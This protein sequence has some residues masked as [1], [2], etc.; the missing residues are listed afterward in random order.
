MTLPSDSKTP[1]DNPTRVDSH[2]HV[3]TALKHDDLA[4]ETVAQG[5]ALSGHEHLI[6]WETVRTFKVASVVCLLAAFSA[7]ADGYEIAVQ[8]SIIANKGFIQQFATAVNEE[9]EKFLASN[10]IATWS[11][12]QNVGQVLGQIGISFVVDRFGRKISCTPSGPSS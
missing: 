7:G 8:A 6:F 5:Q 9:S 4:A 11:A 12:G 2:D 10:I 1:V 3:E